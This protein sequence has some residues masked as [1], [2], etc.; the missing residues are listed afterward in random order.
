VVQVNGSKILIT[1]ASSGIG[2]EL[3]KQLAGRSCT[4]ALLARRKEKLEELAVEVKKLGGEAHVF[5]C[6]VGD[7]DA[8]HKAFSEADKAL[9]GLDIIILNAG[10]GQPTPV[11]ESFSAEKVEWIFRINV[12][13]VIYGIEAILPR[14]LER[15]RGAIVAVSSLAGYRGLPGS[16]A[17]GGSK[18]AVTN[19]LEGMRVELKPK[20]IDVIVVSP[21]F[22]ETPMTGKNKF[23][24]PFLMPVEKAVKV[25]IRGIE[26]GSREVQFPLPLFLI[27][28]TAKM[29]PNFI[30]DRL[31]NSMA[32]KSKKS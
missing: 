26:K 25:M 17:Y 24:M 2:A 19:M 13:G 29:L 8:V 31:A 30:W 7:R 21:G 22:V 1:G 12:F 18:A 11:N 3:S 14:F 27:L 6:D 15:G 32:P 9:G 20:N 23:K 4:L 28:S 16:T 10:V 5:P